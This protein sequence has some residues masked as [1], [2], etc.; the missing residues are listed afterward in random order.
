MF[1]PKL[2]TETRVSILHRVLPRIVMAFKKKWYKYLYS[3]KLCHNKLTLFL[4]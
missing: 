1:S 3:N 4:I 2:L